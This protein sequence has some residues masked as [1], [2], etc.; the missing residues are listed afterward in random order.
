MSEQKTLFARKATGLV[1]EYGI[2]I[3]IM[4][5]L[6]NAVG[7]G[8]QLRVFQGMGWYPLPRT[9]YFLGIP[10]VTMAFLITGIGCLL[11]VYA[12]AVVV[13]AMPRSGGGYIAIS[14]ILSPLWGVVATLFQ[15]MG[16]AAAYGQIAVFVM[17]AFLI[18]GGFVGIVELGFFAT[19]IGLFVFGAI[20][21]AVFSAVAALGARLTG[22]L[23]QIIFWIPVAV[24][25]VVLLLFIIATPATMAAGVQELF[26][27]SATEYIQQALDTGMADAAASNTYWGAVVGAIIA[28]YWAFIGYASTNFIAGEVK[29]SSRTLPRA[30]IASTVIITLIYVLVSF[31]LVGAGAKAG[32]VEG[33]DLVGATSYLNFGG[34]DFG[35]LV[36]IGPWMPVFAH[37]Q[38]VGMGIGALTGFLT[39][40]FAVLWAANDIPP[41]ILTC[42]R[43]LF[44]MAFDRVLPEKI[45][46]VNER[47][48]SPVNA[49]IATSFVALLGA[50]GESG[51]F[52]E[53]G[54]WLGS[55]FK[56]F[57][58][59]F[60]LMGSN[61]WDAIFYASL[62][63]AAF[64][65][66]IVKPRVF[67]RAPFRASKT[68]VQII[69]A[70]GALANLFF[71]YI[72]VFNPR[73]YDLP[74]LI[75][76]PTFAKFAV[77]LAT[78]IILVVGL[79]FY[80]GRKGKGTDYST[81]FAEIPPE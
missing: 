73:A 56:A 24:L 36:S 3:A 80:Y 9:Q 53:G 78:I 28:T 32:V 7:V 22:L 18:F 38:G 11:S 66:P 65:F 64:V 61:L 71:L 44:A 68:T 48:H 70:L 59:G 20:I 12:F 77:W 46:D 58:D 14:R 76:E 40:V 25:G 62:A 5:P 16:V 6:A 57:F 45:A 55:G 26:G 33:F 21:I 50:A 23:L 31:L 15:W 29:E 1:R 30:M 42:S 49:V 13:S 60:G 63:I 69:G 75:R 72:F 35:S 19:P 34:G 39:L 81:I 47:W 67:E 74:G 27:A 52:S 17:E 51:L 41:F 8:W 37:I 43:M 10:P 2:L 4:I 54:I 79:A